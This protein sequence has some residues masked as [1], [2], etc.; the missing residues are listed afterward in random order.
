GSALDVDR[1]RRRLERSGYRHVETVY[2]HGE[3][4]L[5]GALID[6]FPMGSPLPYRIDLLDD[7]VDTLRTFDPE[8]QRTVARMD[9][10]RLLPAR[11][12]PLT[13]DA[14]ARFQQHWYE[15]FEGDPDQSTVFTEVSAGRVPGGCEYYLPLFF[16][17]CETLF[18][19]LPEDAA[20]VTVGRHHEAAQRFW[21]EIAERH[22]EYGI[23]PRRPLLPPPVGFLPVEELYARLKGHA[24]LELRLSA[25]APVHVASGAL[26]PPR[27]DGDSRSELPARLATLTAGH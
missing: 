22:S 20:V 10:V 14:I 1:F 25:E 18:D 17:H 19:Y 13:R 12:F 15:Q 9:A 7:E 27:S 3:F 8:T 2:E 6:I 21:G 4:A 23:D 16:D 26:E 11:E 24:V 5:R